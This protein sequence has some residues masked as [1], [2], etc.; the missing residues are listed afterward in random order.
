M[1]EE[2][3]VLEFTVIEGGKKP[4]FKK[5]KKKESLTYRGFILWRWV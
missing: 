3:F 5:K 1:R 4:D 2:I